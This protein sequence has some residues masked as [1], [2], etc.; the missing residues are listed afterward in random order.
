[1]KSAKFLLLLLSLNA[2]SN[3]AVKILSAHII[4]RIFAIISAFSC[5]FYV[6]STINNELD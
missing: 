5:W 3:I 2:V 1:M 4:P 6:N